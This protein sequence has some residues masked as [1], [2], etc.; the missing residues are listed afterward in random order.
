MFYYIA[1][2]HFFH[3]NIIRLC[4]RPFTD[5]REM[6]NYILDMWNKRVKPEDTV[7]IVGDVAYRNNPEETIAFLKKLK[8]KKLLI[9][10]NHDTKMLAIPEFRALFSEID[11]MKLVYDNGQRVFLC[12][13]PMVEWPGYFS[14]TCHVYGH[15]HN[16]TQN[17][18]FRIVKDLPN[19]FNAGV[20]ITGFTPMTLEELKEANRK[21][22]GK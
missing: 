14:G 12:H 15:I 1:D 19:A 4:N 21:F 6:N 2:T 11:Q 5:S 3:E 7:H 9:E 13:Y 20:D 22:Y 17:N 16:N 18:A 10:G 8:G